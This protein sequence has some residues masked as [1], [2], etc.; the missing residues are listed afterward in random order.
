MEDL[1]CSH[2]YEAQFCIVDYNSNGRGQSLGK[3]NNSLQ[4][5]GRLEEMQ[6]QTKAS[7]SSIRFDSFRLYWLAE[8]FGTFPSF[9]V[10]H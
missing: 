7:S 2:F 10:F 1:Q 6:E 5:N 9:S 8:N 3:R 4:Q